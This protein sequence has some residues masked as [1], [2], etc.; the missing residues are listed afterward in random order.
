MSVRDDRSMENLQGSS[1]PSMPLVR[2]SMTTPT[3]PTGTMGLYPRPTPFFDA[4]PS[5][6]ERF[7]GLSIDNDQGMSKT[8]GWITSNIILAAWEDG[9]EREIFNGQFIFVIPDGNAAAITAHREITKSQ[10]AVMTLRH[11][12][13]L[14]RT[15]YQIASRAFG[16][17]LPIREEFTD[18]QVMLMS[19]VP[20]RNWRRLGFLRD[21]LLDGDQDALSKQL[22]FLS[23]S[24]ILERFNPY[25][26]IDGQ[27]PGDGH[28]KQVAVR[29]AGTMED[30]ENMWGNDIVPGDNLYFILRRIYNEGKGEWQQ[31]AFIPWHGLH[32]PSIADRTYMDFSGNLEVGC[33]IFIG[34]VDRFTQKDGLRMSDLPQLIGIERCTLPRVKI[35]P[36]PGCLRITATGS[37]NRL[38]WDF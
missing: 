29:R 11:V 30:V 18:D 34:S 6:V 4:L 27:V 8:M 3:A 35:G 19:N 33:A 36:E 13:E 1:I 16:P 31:F 7:R 21:K 20:V 15:G 10:M 17:G 14:L 32:S 25:G 12:N 23:E 5:T 2:P 24:M 28:L 22:L 9:L 38:P 37:K 26:W